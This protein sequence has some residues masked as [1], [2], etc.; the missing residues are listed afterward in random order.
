M[1][2]RWVDPVWGDDMMAIADAAG[3]TRRPE[4]IH[5][6]VRGRLSDESL[7][8]TLQ[9]WSAQI[10]DDAVLDD[11]FLHPDRPIGYLPTSHEDCHGCGDIL[12]GCEKHCMGLAE[13]VCGHNGRP[14][15]PTCAPHHC[16][17][18]AAERARWS[19]DLNERNE[20]R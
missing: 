7:A 5:P 6:S 8:A 20:W 9:D 4:P 15:C 1:S 3:V 13:D 14:Y 12:C 11:H 2:A 16:H 19:Y 10:T 18:C 17:D